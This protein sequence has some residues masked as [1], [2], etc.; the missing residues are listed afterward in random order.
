MPESQ[1]EESLLSFRGRLNRQPFIGA[2]ICIWIATLAR[3]YAGD[4]T[5]TRDRAPPARP[6]CDQ[7]PGAGSAP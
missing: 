2:M 1:A 7:A 3:L 6:A 5:A 4:G